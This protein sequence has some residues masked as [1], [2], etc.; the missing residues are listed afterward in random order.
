MDASDAKSPDANGVEIERGYGWLGAVIPADARLFRVEDPVLAEIL[1]DAGAQLVRSE[2]DV[3]I[4]PVRA[5]RGD[6][7]LAIA[8]LGR[9]A[10]SPRPLPLRRLRT[11]PPLAVRA[12]RRLVRSLQ[13]RLGVRSA[14]RLVRSLG[15]ETVRPLLWDHEMALRPVGRPKRLRARII[16]SLPQRAL[17]IGSRRRSSTVFD[18]ALADAARTLGTTLD[19]GPPSVRT[20]TL[21]VDTKPGV[22]RLAVGP[23]RR[24]ILNQ[25]QALSALHDGQAPPF[26][27]AHIPLELAGGRSGIADWSLETRLPGERA[28][29][30]VSG[31]LLSDCVEFLAALHLVQ[32]STPAE[33]PFLDQA[34]VVAGACSPETAAAVRS[35]AER[36]EASL[37]DVP[38]GFA[39]GDFFHGNILVR[40]GRLSGVVDWDAAGPGRLPLLDLLHLALTSL[41]DMAD[42]DW[43][44]LLLRHLV[45]WGRTGGGEI[46]RCYCRLAGLDVDAQRLEIFVAAYWLDYVSYQLITHLHRTARVEWIHRNVA[47]VA[48]SIEGTKLHG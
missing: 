40:D 41:S 28:S 33:N 11:E 25:R 37:S 29:R 3:E 8:V 42:E 44:P 48:K 43:G 27:T 14:R 7:T 18:G 32:N 1:A 22:L 23:G 46:V 35:L 17:V 20:E 31:T 5:L 47:L 10:R 26:V 12:V 9:P 6:A 15:Y 24:Q 39:H 36:L 16:E 19:P 13:V 21:I 38:R 2:P 4:A 45:P 30:P 34:E